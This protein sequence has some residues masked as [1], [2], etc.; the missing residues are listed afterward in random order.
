[1]AAT[2]GIQVVPLTRCVGAEVSGVDLR[3]PLEADETDR[4][5]AALLDHLVLFFRDQ[6]LTSEQHLAFARQF[7]EI[8]IPPFAPRYGDDAAVMVLDQIAPEGEGGDAWHSDNTFMET[9]PMGSILRAVELPGVGC[10][11]RPLKSDSK[12]P[13]REA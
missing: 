7:G 6:A 9:P 2:A 8:S 5:R 10:T 1:M 3:R 11:A 13:Y 12:N 4:L